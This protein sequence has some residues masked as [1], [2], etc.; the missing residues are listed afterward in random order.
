MRGKIRGERWRNRR[1]R[2][3]EVKGDI[4]RV[5]LSLMCYNTELPLRAG[6]VHAA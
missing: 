2:G 4:S 1:E 3:R 5:S 6:L